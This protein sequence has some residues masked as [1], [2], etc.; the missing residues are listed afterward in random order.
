MLI[1]FEEYNKLLV[2][3]K[4]TTNI[5]LNTYTQNTDILKKDYFQY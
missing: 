4:V 3:G 5:T 2:T 1:F